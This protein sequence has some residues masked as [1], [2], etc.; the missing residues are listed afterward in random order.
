MH[1]EPKGTG[2]MHLAV[3]SLLVVTANAALH[4][5]VIVQPLPHAAISQLSLHAA[6]PH[7]V[8]APSAA[9]ASVLSRLVETSPLLHRVATSHL[10]ASAHHAA[11]ILTPAHAQIVRRL[12]VL[13]T[14]VSQRVQAVSSHHVRA[15]QVA[16]PSRLA[17]T[18]Q[19]A[20]ALRVQ[21]RHALQPV[22]VAAL[23][24]TAVAVKVQR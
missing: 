24:L 1:Q 3:T 15:L 20:Q 13:P 14:Q 12:T 18:A 21:A 2:V 4:R 10:V 19:L 17:A 11:T 7:V 16:K 6:T 22:H 23:T 8:T 5:A 9:I